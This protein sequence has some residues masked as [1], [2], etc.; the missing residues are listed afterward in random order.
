MVA[1]AS[2]NAG[3]GTVEEVVV[4]DLAAGEAAWTGACTSI[5]GGWSAGLIGSGGWAGPAGAGL[6]CACDKETMPMN[7]TAA[8]QPRCLIEVTIIRRSEISAGR[9]K[10]GSRPAL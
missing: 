1:S 10:A 4:V 7:A 9:I 2:V 5:M 8:T 6:V 3:A